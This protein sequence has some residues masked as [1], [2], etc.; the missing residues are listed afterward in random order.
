M[1]ENISQFLFQYMDNPDPQYA[2]M[3]KGKWG[4]GKSFFIQKWMNLYKD[5]LIKGE[6]TL[7][8]IYISLYG[9]KE[10]SQITKAIDKVLH[11][12]LYSKGVEITKKILKIA[13]RIAFKANM[14]WDDDGKTDWTMES[15]L[16]SLSLLTSNDDEAAFI[17]SKLIVFDDLERC[18]IDMKILL[19]YINT[20]VEHG[21]CH[22]IIIGD[23]THVTNDAKDKLMEFKEKTVGREFEITPDLEAA[24]DYFTS[25]DI[26][27]SN[28]FKK[29]KSIILEIFK[30]TKCDNLRILRQCL[31]DF[32]SL[33]NE[34]NNKLLK[35]GDSYLVSLLGSYIVTYCEYRGECREI[36]RRWDWLYSNSIWGDEKTKETISALQ[37]KYS[38]I[39]DNYQID[40]LNPLH[41]K[42][43]VHEIE[44]GY[45]LRNSVENSLNQMVGNTSLQDKLT[46]FFKLSNDEFEKA[47]NE[48][49]KDVRN[50]RLPNLFLMGKS[51]ALLILFD[52]NQIKSISE[53]TVSLAKKQILKIIESIDSKETLYQQKNL[54]IQGVSSS[55]SFYENPNGKDIIDYVTHQFEERDKIL[56]SKMEEA[57]VNLNDE[58][59]EGLIKLSDDGLINQSRSYSLPSIFKNVDSNNFSDRILK[60]NNG[61]L[62]SLCLFFSY[63]YM[64]G[65]NLS[66]GSNHFA[67][68]APFLQLVY[69]RLGNELPN[70]NSVNKYMLNKLLKHIDGAIKRANGDNN[71]IDIYHE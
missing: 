35:K 9:L 23:E 5:N 37:S 21:A 51:L 33:Y 17:G 54:F 10:P 27:I 55:G 65:F 46:N 2:V 26:P 34:I 45:S 24:F 53:E 36:L 60:L 66:S 47:Y 11:P 8:P 59:V 32:G 12:F 71:P 22:V 20:F 40:V 56:L 30:S 63:H 41:I 49:E 68:D 15:T 44:T 62:Q 6:A 64:F 4:C 25:G 58:N 13:G 70:R 42:E 16:D 57:L 3:L 69:D 48:L 31:Y 61:S 29:Q 18:L 67:D 38:S 28:W 19:G 14:D 39:V 43:I 52:N 1:N 50:N 7:E